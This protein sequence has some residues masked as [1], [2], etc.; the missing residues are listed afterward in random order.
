MELRTVSGKVLPIAAQ[1]TFGSSS[2]LPEEQ[3]FTDENYVSKEQFWVLPAADLPGALL[4]K[5]IGTN[6]KQLL[7]SGM[8]DLLSSCS[9]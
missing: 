7:S 9:C 4:L 5:N 2:T 8:D 1:L 6:S 3:Q